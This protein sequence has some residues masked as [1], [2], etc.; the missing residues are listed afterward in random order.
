MVGEIEA[1]D[2]ISR[3]IIYHR[4]FEGNVH[5][6]DLLFNFGQA[7]ADGAAHESAVLRS[8]APTDAD[9]HR[10]GCKIVAKQN[11][12]PATKQSDRR[13]YCGFRTADVNALPLEGD[14]YRIELTNVEELG[15][16]AHVDVALRIF[17]TG[18]NPRATRRTAAGMALAEKFGP[19]SPHICP[20]DNDDPGHPIIRWGVQC[21][22][23]TVRWATLAIPTANDASE[24]QAE[25]QVG[26]A[27][28]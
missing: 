14:G 12:L 28:S 11:D 10:I 9:V 7:K 16:K 18:S 1:A 4:F 13:Y 22:G 25:L 8:L 26:V 24:L 23:G 20:S 17:V 6:N 2:R 21:L 5:V 27:T 3:C 19:V 15:E